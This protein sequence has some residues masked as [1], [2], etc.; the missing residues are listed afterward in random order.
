VD[1]RFQNHLATIAETS[2]SY[3]TLD[4]MKKDNV[5]D[6][7]IDT[8]ANLLYKLGRKTEALKYQEEAILV[9]KK[10]EEGKKP[11][12]ENLNKMQAN[13]PTWPEKK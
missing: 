12:F 6:N 9:S 7:A 10:D 11:L 1:S 2:R 4:E 3:S 5:A 13:L 8:Y